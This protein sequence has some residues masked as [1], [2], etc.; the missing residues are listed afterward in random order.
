MVTLWAFATS[1]RS[2][3]QLLKPMGQTAQSLTHFVS[4]EITSMVDIPERL[5]TAGRP[6]DPVFT[7]TEKMFHRFR[8]DYFQAGV[9]LN[10]GFSSGPSFNR[11]KFSKPAD[12]L[13]HPEDKYV[14]YGV[15]SI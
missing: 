9:F 11:E 3:R 12:V 14:G 7:P 8:P 1:A 10:V 5:M 6:V 4:F 15:L 2:P 13:L